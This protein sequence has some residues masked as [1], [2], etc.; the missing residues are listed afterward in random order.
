MPYRPIFLSIQF[1]R[2]CCIILESDGSN[3]P[4]SIYYKVCAEGLFLLEPWKAPV[5]LII[6]LILTTLSI[7]L[8]IPMFF[9]QTTFHIQVICY[10][11][12]N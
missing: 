1:I 2:R 6:L 4:G 12:R 8:W 9:L 11:G 10:E 5:Q 3:Y 7:D